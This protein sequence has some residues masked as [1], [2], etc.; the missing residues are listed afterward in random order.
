MENV[1]DLMSSAFQ[2]DTLSRLGSQFHEPPKAI[3]RGLQSALPASV[4]AL[5]THV[6]S[7]QSAQDL[8][9]TFRKGDYPHVEADEVASVAADPEATSRLAQSSSGFLHQIFG[10]R[11]SGTVDAIASDSGI[12]RGSATSLLG[13]AAPLMLGFFG[14]QA[15]SNNLDAGGLLGMV[16]DQG[17][18]A[19]SALPGP[20][21]KV[22]GGALPSVGSATGGASDSASRVQG[23]TTHATHEVKAPHSRRGLLWA[24]LAAALAFLAWRMFSQRSTPAIEERP[25]QENYD[26]QREA[27][28]EVPRTV[29]RDRDP[30]VPASP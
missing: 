14:K 2:G 8:L 19:V 5:A 23:S 10:N 26:M 28:R 15:K 29:P 4:A 25:A 9:N 12:A 22:L 13:L 18:K 11:L 6:T 30:G 27:P 1:M 7:K 17:R 16:T 24:L 21:S 3:R 20:L